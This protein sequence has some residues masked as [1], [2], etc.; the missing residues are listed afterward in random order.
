MINM[1]NKQKKA[2]KDHPKE[3]HGDIIVDIKQS[4]Y[5]NLSNRTHKMI[6]KQFQSFSVKKFGLMY[7]IRNKQIDRNQNELWKLSKELKE[8]RKKLK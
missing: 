6:D 8:M 4:R 7:H 2:L 3:F 5:D 1:N